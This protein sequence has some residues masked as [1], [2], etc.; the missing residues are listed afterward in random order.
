MWPLLA[1]RIGAEDEE[2]RT[3][4]KW[5]NGEY[6]NYR[7]W[8]KESFN[9]HKEYKLTKEIFDEVL[10]NA[11]Y[12]EGVVEFFKE[13]DRT[14][15]IPVIISG[16]FQELVD[17]ACEEL[18]IDWGYGACR[19]TFNQVT[20]YLEKHS[21]KSSDFKGKNGWLGNIRIEE[22]LDSGDHW[23]FVGDGKNDIDIATKAKAAFAINPHPELEAVCGL[24]KIESFLDL[25]PYLNDFDAHVA[26]VDNLKRTSKKK[27]VEK[28]E[29]EQ[30]KV[31]WSK[32]G[33]IL[34]VG[35]CASTRAN[36]ITVAKKYN[37]DSKKIEYYKEYNTKFDFKLLENNDKY[38]YLLLGQ[39][40]HKVSGIGD[41]S[42]MYSRIKNNPN[43]YPVKLYRQEIINREIS[44]AEVEKFFQWIKKDR[45]KQPSITRVVHLTNK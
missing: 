16:G 3:H 32:D 25:L 5:E 29:K 28:K 9:F 27:S 23:A 21:Y 26:K 2:K 34:I 38:S 13:L 43:V 41:A 4:D 24:E 39:I 19:Y 31:A 17:R 20:G 44:L 22:E 8:V 33:I 7:E 11:E 10:K 42:S 40:P 14:K 35:Q 15:W 30:T 1:Y 36:V 45:A 12:N 6:K 37:I 18:N